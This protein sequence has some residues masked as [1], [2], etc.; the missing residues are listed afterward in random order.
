MFILGKLF[1]PSLMF[2][3]K[4]SC[5][6]LSGGHEGYF[7]QVGSGLTCKHYTRLEKFASDKHSS[8]LRK[9]VNYGRKKF[10]NIDPWSQSA[11]LLGISNK[12]FMLSVIMLDVEAPK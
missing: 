1:Q 12:P 11:L 2:V 4:A 6:P 8:L 9:F 7:T 3:G 5:L 10:Y